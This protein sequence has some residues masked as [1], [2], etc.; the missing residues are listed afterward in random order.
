MKTNSDILEQNLQKRS[1]N[2]SEVDGRRLAFIILMSAFFFTCMA[3]EYGLGTFLPVFSVHSKVHS[4][5]SQ[6]AFVKTILSW[7]L[8]GGRLVALIIANILAPQL[9]LITS[10]IFCVFGGSA[11]WILGPYSIEALEVMINTII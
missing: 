10:M 1:A 8:A 6:A 7:S 9:M 4:T 3:M 5:E 11:L 2:A